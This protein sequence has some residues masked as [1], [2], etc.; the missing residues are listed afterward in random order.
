MKGGRFIT[1]ISL[2]LVLSA[3]TLSCGTREE[4]GEKVGVVVT[5]LPQVEFVE[6]VGGER[7]EV[8]VM[9]PP[10]ASPHTY[11]PSPSQMA[12]LSKAEMYAKVGTA[13]EF[14]LVWMDRLIAINKEMLVVDCSKGVQLIEMVGEPEDEHEHEAMDPHIWMSP[15]NVKIMVHNIYEGLVQVD[16]DNKTYYEQNRDAYL[17]ELSKLDQDIR[18]GLSGMT[19][20]TFMVYHPAFGYFAKEY[21]LAMLPIEVE[22]K[23]PTASSIAHL[24]E[25]AKKHDIKVIF[26]SP[27]FN[28]QSAEVIAKAIGG[29]VVFIDSL[30]KDYILNMRQ[31]LGELVQL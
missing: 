15:L 2:V 4:A 17:W 21:N 22:G 11:E 5:I 29:R 18:D 8:S 19:N 26:A 20:R 1:V 6:S 16:P 31:L 27:Q 25:Q 24:I 3:S 23:E 7:V 10:G 13:V 28:P 12:A 14:E 30:A 9:V